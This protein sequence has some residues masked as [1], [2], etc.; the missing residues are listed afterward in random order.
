MICGQSSTF[1]VRPTSQDYFPATPFS[2]LGEQGT[3]TANSAKVKSV[4]SKDLGLSQRTQPKACELGP[5]KTFIA[6]SSEALRTFIACASSVKAAFRTQQTGWP[7]TSGEAVMVREM[8]GR[9]RTA[10]QPRL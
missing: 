10:V 5:R 9:D 1:Q 3:Y 4:T 2:N 8:V 7:V 6:H